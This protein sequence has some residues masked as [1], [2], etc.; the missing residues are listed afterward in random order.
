MFAFLFDSNDPSLDSEYGPPCTSR[1]VQAIERLSPVPCTQI[2]WGDILFGFLAYDIERVSTGPK[3]LGELESTSTE[4]R[5]T[6]NRDMHVTLVCDLAETLTVAPS[7]TNE[8]KLMRTL[9]QSVVWAI[10][11]PSLI[12]SEALE[13][14]QQ[15]KGFGPYL[16][17]A[18]LDPGNPTHRN[19]MFENMTSGA[20]V[21]H[22][23]LHYEIE[24]GL[25]EADVDESRF[26]AQTF[27]AKLGLHLEEPDRF[28][29]NC[30]IYVLPTSDSQRGA[31]SGQRVGGNIDDSHRQRV[32]R[33][34]LD[35]FRTMPQ[36][37]SA[38]F[39]AKTESDREFLVEE[40]KAR[41]YL[42]NRNH[43]QGGPKAAF[44]ID[45]LGIEPSDW[46]Y[47]ADQLEAGVKGAQLFRVSS[48]E[49]GFSHRAHIAVTGRNGVVAAVE[50]GW[51]LRDEGA[52]RLV[53]AYP[54]SKDLATE[55]ERAQSRV[56]NSELAGEARWQAI[57]DLA[58]EFGQIASK[59][60]IPTPMVLERFGTIWDGMC[61]HA[62]V[63]LADARKP[64]AAW[65]KKQQGAYAS[66]PGVR[67]Y[68]RCH[69]QSIDRN[70]AYSDAFAE[71]LRANGIDCKVGS[72]L[73]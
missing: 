44:F 60:V 29:A 2:L 20:Y 38:T 53:T 30:P 68:A 46:R 70:K 59:S 63:Q 22:E 37:S 3:K 16:G 48:S 23:G 50:T 65:L 26:V 36:G 55:L 13:V 67:L 1:V 61:G 19:I 39:I 73:D 11:T 57:F 35:Y 52:A 58:D 28:R 64:F 24:S 49:Y 45:V 40:T 6:G 31:L 66:S 42:L 51:Q 8:T 18:A 69:E 62:W 71:V 12:A 47:L 9:A 34:A 4:I 17:V 72:R 33:A 21:N 56:V 5:Y 7:T 10:V 41:D 14:D 54:A 32:A 25:D 15:L 43:P 27:G